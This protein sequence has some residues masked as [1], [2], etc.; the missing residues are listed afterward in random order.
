M[1]FIRPALTRGEKTYLYTLLP[2]VFILFAGG[3]AFAYFVLLPPAL[4]FLLT[5]GSD[6]AEPMIKVKNY[7][8]VMV[9]LLFWI[10]I[11]FEIPLVIFFLSKIGILSVERL[12]KFR[13]WAYVL[14]FIMGA[15][16]TPT[17]DPVNQTL[18][19]V[20]III[21]FEFGTLLARIAKRKKPESV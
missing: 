20:P 2:S 17:F 3:V 7:V 12:K 5:F 1:T 4:N 14:A 18:V 6:I 15:A 16:I 8:S 10:G 13:P 19:A 21:L 9:R 11:C